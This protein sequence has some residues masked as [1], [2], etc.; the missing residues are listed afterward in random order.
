M[1]Y[2]WC[3][4]I[5]LALTVVYGPYKSIKVTRCAFYQVREHHVWHIQLLCLGTGSS[6]GGLCQPSWIRGCVFWLVYQ[7]IHHV[8]TNKVDIFKVSWWHADYDY[9]GLTSGNDTWLF[10][11][12][13]V[14]K[15]LSAH[16]WILLSRLTYTAYLVLP[17][18]LFVF[19]G[20]F[21]TVLAYSDLHL[22]SFSYF[23]L[24]NSSKHSL[25][26]WYCF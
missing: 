11:T 17:I 20:S 3:V 4:D 5:A 8:A 2:C 12:G 21:E 18:V 26:H 25:K 7:S 14:I 13:L 23:A 9:K 16:F 24:I 19:F 1:L 10:L 15:I 22:V 6:L